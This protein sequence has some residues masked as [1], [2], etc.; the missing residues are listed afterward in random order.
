MTALDITMI[1]NIG[2]LLLGITAW[3]LACFA[4]I[5]KKPSVSHRFSFGS[6]ILCAFSLLLQLLEVSNRV[7]IHDFSAIT[8][9]I[10][11]VITASCI[12]IAITIIL[13][14]IALVKASRNT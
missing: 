11:A 1:H 5:S 13:N 12:L 2:S 10:H 7:N 14:G 6:F 9:T 4:I 3:L 8:D